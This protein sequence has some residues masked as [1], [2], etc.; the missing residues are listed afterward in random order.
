MPQ[1]RVEIIATLRD[2][3]SGPL[4]RI[5][6][7]FN[8]LRADT[9]AGVGPIAALSAGFT[10]FRGISTGIIS[11]IGRINTAFGSVIRS[12]F[13]LRT[14]L[15]ALGG[16]LAIG[17]LVR[18]TA[19]VDKRVRE[20]GTLL[21]NV[22][23]AQLGELSRNIRD[24]AVEGA[25]TLEAEFTA[26]YQAISAGVPADKLLTFLRTANQ[27]AVAGVSTTAETTNLLTGVLNAYGE[28]VDN[29]QRISDLLFQT[30]VL[31]KTTVG[32]LA[33]SMGQVAP[34][35]RVMGVSIEELSASFVALTRVLGRTDTAATSLR[36][37][38]AS[39]QR[40]A[41]R[42]DVQQALGVEVSPAALREKGLL[43]FIQE[44]SVAIERNQDALGELGFEMQAFNAASIL[45][46]DNGKVL[47][48][49]L[50]AMEGAAGATQRAFGIMS[51]S[52][53]F[54]L[55][56]FRTQLASVV[57][58]IGNLLLPSL[59]ALF[60]T[61]TARLQD[62]QK[63]ARSTVELFRIGFVDEDIAPQLRE[64]ARRAFQDSL[65]LNLRLA[66]TFAK[67]LA[68][69][70]ATAVIESLKV[71]FEA[72]SPVITRAVRDAFANVPFFGANI[73]KSLQAQRRE[74]LPQLQALEGAVSQSQH[75]IDLAADRLREAQFTDEAVARI[76]DHAQERAALLGPGL[77]P[78]EDTETVV[79]GLTD[80]TREFVR[81]IESEFEKLYARGG[82]KLP[83][84]IA[85]AEVRSEIDALDRQIEQEAII[86]QVNLGKAVANAQEKINAQA[87]AV[88]NL[89]DENGEWNTS[90]SSVAKVLAQLESQ[91]ARNQTIIDEYNKTLERQ[92]GIVSQVINGINSL[93]N[94]M[95]AYAAQNKTTTLGIRSQIRALVEL[96]TQIQKIADFQ[97]SLEP[98]RLIAVGQ[99]DEARLVQQ[100]IEHERELLE[101]RQEL[102]KQGEID[103]LSGQS[104]VAALQRVQSLER[105][106]LQVS[107]A[108]AEAQRERQKLEER[109]ERTLR[110]IERAQEANNITASDAAEQQL[111][112]AQ[113]ISESLDAQ[114]ARLVELQRLHPQLQ[115]LIEDEI[116][117]AKRLKDEINGV[118]P[119]ITAVRRFGEALK[120]S[121]AGISNLSTAIGDTIGG[122]IGSAIDGI[123]TRTFKWRDALV[124][125]LQ[126]LASI[127]LRTAAINAIASAFPGLGVGAIGFAKGGFVP[128]PDTGRDNR[129]IAVRG[130]E[131]V[132]RPEAVKHYGVGFLNF[133]NQRLVPK[134]ILRY[135]FGAVNTPQ[136]RVQRFQHGGATSTSV[137]EASGGFGR[138]VVI[139]DEETAQRLLSN[140]RQAYIEFFRNNR[141]AI[142]GDLA[143][144]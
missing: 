133:L 5:S 59:L 104:R 96:G 47:S 13:N 46:A 122:A 82:D 10:R 20:I 124:G 140:G 138:A 16:A 81:V 105:D 77:L 56:Q 50:Q 139:P 61:I 134:D 78:I 54:T 128:G 117:Q 119:P 115:S 11:N 131:Y 3:L 113:A 79:R 43:R 144:R 65:N 118:A 15:L 4:G 14:A 53:S 23:D 141:H 48:E 71:A 35:A 64:Q 49:A 52:L 143:A 42:T 60:G 91:T 30:V 27:L 129:L 17:G 106:S 75:I 38:L 58:D 62:M 7:A 125:V 136:A 18:V 84:G 121:L 109:R 107:I 12:V 135:I 28:S 137:G 120:Q 93:F 103:T 8:K 87:D 86:E 70:I 80:E 90:T 39:L 34:T 102:K 92:P 19:D 85:L 108:L 44:L 132:L 101:L 142:L 67:E 51:Q 110:E 123:V 68:S 76:L 127:F 2:S 89:K 73:E 21:G 32:E 26:A 114:I 1:N 29:V 97:R 112:S 63:A 55:T 98:R 24:A 74:L 33:V 40:L 45:A 130:Q 9:R 22:S 88:L 100:Q 95:R 83:I 37:L 99:S 6:S 116:E 66:L 111:A 25:Q 36:A 94:S 72:A 57:T 126:Q 31:G 41:K 69:L